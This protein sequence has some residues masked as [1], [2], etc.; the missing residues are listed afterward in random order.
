MVL[1]HADKLLHC[2][3]CFLAFRGVIIFIP[4]QLPIITILWCDI[5]VLI[6]ISLTIYDF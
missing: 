5:D 2:E 6:L 4:Q 1:K 3:C